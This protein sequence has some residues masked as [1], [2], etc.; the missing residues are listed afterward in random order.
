MPETGLEPAPPFED[1]LLRPA[2]LPI[3]PPGQE[4]IAANVAR[5]AAKNKL[6]QQILASHLKAP[7]NFSCDRSFK[8]SRKTRI[9]SLFKESSL[10][11]DQWGTSLDTLLS[12]APIAKFFKNTFA[13]KWWG[14]KTFPKA[15]LFL[16]PI[17]EGKFPSMECSSSIP[18]SLKAISLALH[19]L[20]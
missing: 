16:S 11:F 5:L 9:E 7:Y 6:A 18:F 12:I 20:W 10:R 1:R 2:C 15:P 13:L 4:S 17:T 8:P 19:E 14:L 3:P